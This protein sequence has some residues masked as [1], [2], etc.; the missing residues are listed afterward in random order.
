MKIAPILIISACGSLGFAQSDSADR[1]APVETTATA[2]SN[3]FIVKILRPLAPSAKGAPTA[4]TRLKEFTDQTMGPYALLRQAAT[5]AWS[6][7]VDSYREWGQ[8]SEGYAERFGNSFAINATH[9]TLT[10]GAKTLLHEDNRYFASGETGFLRRMLH[11]TVSPFVTHHDDGSAGFSY[12]NAFGVVGAGFISRA[13]APPSERGADHAFST[14][15]LCFAEGAAVNAV[16]E[17][18][19]DIIRKFQKR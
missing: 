5:A 18:V 6:Q 4:Q 1:L 10:Y 7:G 16:R 19:P 11:A 15:G 2:P 13:W 14:M 9:H 8:G 12:S 3:G 17:F